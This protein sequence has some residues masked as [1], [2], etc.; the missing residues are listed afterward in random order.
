MSVKVTISAGSEAEREAVIGRLRSIGVKRVKYAPKAPHSP[1]YRAF[2]D[3]CNPL[4]CDT[5][6]SVERARVPRQ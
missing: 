4:D 1:Y 3:L 5:I 6:S 2:I